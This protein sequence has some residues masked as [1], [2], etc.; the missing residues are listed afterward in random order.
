MTR[1]K[2]S[3]V[4]KWLAIAAALFWLIVIGW[5]QLAGLDIQRTAHTYN[6]QRQSKYCMGD[7]SERY[8]CRSAI[9]VVGQQHNFG[10]WIA[11]IFIVFGPP[12]AIGLVYHVISR[13]VWRRAEADRRRRYVAARK[14]RIQSS[15]AA[16]PR[17]AGRP[18]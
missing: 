17:A 16:G 14:A 1:T 15:N 2:P 12:I 6:L 3:P 7:A 5:Q 13:R 11:R 10:F 8:E 9:R 4:L 18:A